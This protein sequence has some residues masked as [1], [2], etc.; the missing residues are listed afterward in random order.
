MAV[1]LFIFA[2]TACRLIKDW[3]YLPEEQLRMILKDGLAS[4]ASRNDQTYLPVVKQLLRGQTKMQEKLLAE[5]FREM[6]GT[7]VV[8][9]TPLSTLSLSRLLNRAPIKSVSQ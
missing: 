5:Q 1:P 9:E 2:A 3:R 4:Q 7:I 6:V 8:L